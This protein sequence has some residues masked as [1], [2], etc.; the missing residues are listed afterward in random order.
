MLYFITPVDQRVSGVVLLTFQCVI[1][2]GQLCPIKYCTYSLH[3]SY[4]TGCITAFAW[5]ELINECSFECFI[6]KLCNLGG[7]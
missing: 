5:K 3:N 6:T 1:M 4:L 2:N 7:S